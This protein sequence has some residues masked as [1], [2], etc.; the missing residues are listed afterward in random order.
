MYNKITFIDSSGFVDV[1]KNFV[2]FNVL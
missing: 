2:H 1:L